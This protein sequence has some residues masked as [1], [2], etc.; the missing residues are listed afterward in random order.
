M[1][2]LL[3]IDSWTGDFL[4]E[5]NLV[6][7]RQLNE[8]SELAARWG[9]NLADVMLT[10]NWIEPEDY[11]RALADRF[12]VEQVDLEK[13]PLDPDLL[14]VAEVANYMRELAVPWRCEE[15]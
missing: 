1:G 6:S 5:R 4:A 10:K 12:S 11:Y 2:N 8:A 7:A 9:S 13:D 14:E 15:G 3:S